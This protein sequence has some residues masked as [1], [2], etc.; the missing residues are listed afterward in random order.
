MIDLLD[1]DLFD[2]IPG[3]DL[4]L[5]KEKYTRKNIIPVFISERS[6]GKNR[7]NLYELLHDCNMNYYNDLYTLLRG[8]VLIWCIYR[9]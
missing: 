3:L 6:P 8:T 7:E 1:Y 4:S 5:K 9:G 2:G